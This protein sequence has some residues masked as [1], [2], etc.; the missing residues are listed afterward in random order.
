LWALVIT[1]VASLTISQLNALNTTKV[2]TLL[3]TQIAVF[4]TTRL[5]EIGALTEYGGFYR[6]QLARLHSHHLM[7]ADGP[8]WAGEE[9]P[10]APH[11]RAKP[12]AALSAR[13]QAT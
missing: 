4:S 12:K 5:C 9:N 11:V 2:G 13:V 10:D 1:Q 3:D 6:A 7:D 8:L